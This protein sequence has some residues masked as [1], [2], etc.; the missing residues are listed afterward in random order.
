MKKYN[1]VSVDIESL[2]TKPGCIVLSIGVAG[3]DLKRKPVRLLDVRIDVLDSLFIGLEADEATLTW[4]RGQSREAKAAL[5]YGEAQRAAEAVREL[6]EVIEARATDDLRVWM[7]GPSFDGVLL[8]A[9]AERV[10]LELP[11]QYWSERCVR[12]I[13]EGVPEPVRGDGN[14]HHSAVDDALHQAAWVR[15]ALAMKGGK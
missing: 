8:G 13:C 9:L 5:S 11:W 15:K 6:I 7:K 14:V 10:G 3:F 2:G 12:T 4:W 1:H